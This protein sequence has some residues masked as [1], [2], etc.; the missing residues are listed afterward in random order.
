[1]KGPATLLQTR[2]LMVLAVATVLL[3]LGGVLTRTQSQGPEKEQGKAGPDLERLQRKFDESI[4]HRLLAQREV[5]AKLTQPPLAQRRATEQLN[6]RR[7]SQEITVK[8]AEA[9]YQNAKLTREVAEIA[10]IEYEEGILVRDMQTALGEIK[11]AEADLVRA[12]EL[13]E[14]AQRMLEEEKIPKAQAIAADLGLKKAQ[15]G[16]ELAQTKKTV[17][18]KY[19]KGKT[20]KDLMRE[21]EKAESD[22]L[23]GKATW[24]LEKSKLAKLNFEIRASKPSAR[25]RQGLAVLD[26]AFRLEDKVLAGRDEARTLAD[27]L[28]V[29][30]DAG[31]A[32]VDQLKAKQAEVE[33]LADQFQAKL[34]EAAKIGQAIEAERAERIHAELKKEIHALAQDSKE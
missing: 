8:G 10:V 16:L 6:D 32:A 19:T 2:S 9:R 29:R 15:V 26:E 12:R 13:V 34:D 11:L 22:E 30:P 1:M 28:K 24:E 23:A 4:R 27:Q 25:E 21:V 14:W 5:A 18:E 33:R 3:L 31:Q 17:L 7:I 20:I